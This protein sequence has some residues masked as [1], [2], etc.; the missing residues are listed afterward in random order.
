[1]RTPEDIEQDLGGAGTWSLGYTAAGAPSQHPLF[2]MGSD[3]SADFST[4]RI[5]AYNILENPKQPG[6]ESAAT[7]RNRMR[8]RGLCYICRRPAG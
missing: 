5:S 8:K 2:I 3:R 7:S 4:I 6:E 1:M